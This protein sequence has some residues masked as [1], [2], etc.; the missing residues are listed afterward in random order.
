MEALPETTMHED[1][2]QL[3]QLRKHC[4]HADSL[5][6]EASLA[7]VALV[8]QDHFGKDCPVQ[9]RGRRVEDDHSP[10]ASV[11]AWKNIQLLSIPGHLYDLDG[12]TDWDRQLVAHNIPQSQPYDWKKEPDTII[13][14]IFSDVFWR[15]AFSSTKI[16]EAVNQ[17]NGEFQVWK[18]EHDTASAGSARPRP[19]I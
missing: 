16:F 3:L 18:M 6:V 19:R 5:S 14:G 9:I 15:A 8:L 12:P 4:V 11:R 13:D 2:V 7:V 10:L 17:L 1:V